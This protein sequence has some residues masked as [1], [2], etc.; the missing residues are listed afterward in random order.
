MAFSA[1]GAEVRRVAA[2]PTF[3]IEVHRMARGSSLVKRLRKLAELI[4]DD[5]TVR[6]TLQAL[7]PDDAPVADHAIAMIGVSILERALEIAIR[8]RL[9]PLTPDERKRLFKFE[10][11]GP[12]SNFSD[13][14][15]MAYALNLIDSETRD[16]LDLI[17]AIR[18]AFAHSTQLI[19]FNTAEINRDK[20]MGTKNLA[21]V[22]LEHR[23]QPS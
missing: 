10:N 2:R 21:L 9:I 23:L 5:N 20:L 3:Q 15:K 17:R 6:E 12:L 14:I 22:V 1:S 11:H 7:E 8:S 18:N 4:P 19:T 13:R 16:E